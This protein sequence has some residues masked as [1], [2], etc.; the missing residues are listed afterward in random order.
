M[1]GN[2]NAK[3]I[4]QA[5]FGVQH[6][7]AFANMIKNYPDAG[8][9]L[10][11]YLTGRGEYPHPI[12][13]RTPVGEVAP[14]LY[15]HHDLLTVN[16]IFCRGDYFADA[17]IQTVV[18]L[19]SNIGISAL[20][21]F[22][23]NPFSTCY[24]FEPDPRNVEKLK[25]NL[26]GYEAR[27]VLQEK[28]VSNESGILEFGVEPTGRYGGLGRNTG[29]TITVDCVQINDVLSDVLQQ[30]GSIDILKIDTEG[31]EMQTVEAIHPALAAKIKRIYL[32]AEPDRPLHPD[33]FSQKQ[34]GGVCQ[35]TLKNP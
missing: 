8:E 20:Y 28:A 4:V 13:V 1:I 14:M 15:S 35:L 34:Y 17:G 27:Y 7:I 23:R 33:L 11:R 24:L 5:M 6:Y 2:R 10:F 31:V 3:Q 30:R 18:D 16:E 25:K 21:F 29:Q 12:Q 26:A 22:T 9:N 32:E 19:G